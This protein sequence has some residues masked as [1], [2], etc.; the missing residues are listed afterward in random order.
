MNKPCLAF[1]RIPNINQVQIVWYILFRI[2]H[3]KLASFLCTNKAFERFNQG[4]LMKFSY[5]KSIQA[6]TMSRWPYNAIIILKEK[7]QD[8]T[9]GVLKMG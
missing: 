7:H 8:T 5:L 3:I 6:S 4:K 2:P 1:D 9:S